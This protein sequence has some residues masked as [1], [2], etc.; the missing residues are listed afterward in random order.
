ML[1][2][3][4]LEPIRKSGG[5]RSAGI[6]GYTSTV[7]THGDRKTKLSKPANYGSGVSNKKKG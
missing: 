5:R 1:A 2:N 4:S 3:S 6:A 7:S